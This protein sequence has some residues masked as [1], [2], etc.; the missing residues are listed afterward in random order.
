MGPA[1][2]ILTLHP[3]VELVSEMRGQGIRYAL[4]SVGTAD[5]GWLDFV[6]SRRVSTT[7]AMPDTIKNNDLLNAVFDD[8]SILNANK[9]QLRQYLLACT[10]M[11]PS[12]ISN[13]R[14]LEGLPL[15]TALIQHLLAAQQHEATHRALLIRQ[16]WTLIIAGMTLMVV[17]IKAIFSIA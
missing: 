11:R 6:A 3:P 14:V 7:A 16:N 12:D 10:E 4:P 9:E 5:A 8:A 2:R 17:V 1:R 15:R 13:P